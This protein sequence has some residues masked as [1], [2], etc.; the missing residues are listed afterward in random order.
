ME[1]Y[2]CFTLIDI[3]KGNPVLNTILSDPPQ[4]DSDCL[5]LVEYLA[6]N[7]VQV[8][9]VK[10]IEPRPMKTIKQEG[11]DVVMGLDPL[12]Q[13][14]L[15]LSELSGLIREGRSGSHICGRRGSGG[16]VF[17]I[18]FVIPPGFICAE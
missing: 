9:A 15:I 4:L 11:I 10:G 13:T 12:F 18:P 1:F 16:K 8:I 17:T 5:V 2:D 7:D 6:D 3:T 14:L